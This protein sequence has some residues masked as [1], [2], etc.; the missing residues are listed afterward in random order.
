MSKDKLRDISAA[1]FRTVLIVSMVLLVGMAAGGFLFFSDQMTMYAQEVQKSRIEATVSTNDI[2]RLQQ[3]DEQMKKDSVAV[4]RAKSI[5]A[6]STFYQYQDQIIDDITA[7]ARSSN[8][9]ITS[10]N[11]EASGGGAQ[12]GAAPAASSTPGQVAAPAGLKT[13]SASISIKNPVSY[14]SLM[15]FVHSIEQNLTKM[16]ISGL[17]LQLD[18]QSGGTNVNPITVE[19]YTR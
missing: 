13:I 8:L 15:R 12:Q 17:S 2:Q 4:E 1:K 11:F 7:Y 5:V 18:E 16:Q 9:T 14:V 19:V 3:L 6:D 10:I